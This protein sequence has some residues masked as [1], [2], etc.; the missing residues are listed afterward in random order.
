MLFCFKPDGMEEKGRYDKEQID[1]GGRYV[2]DSVNVNL[3]F[4]RYDDFFE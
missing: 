3:C 4:L 2:G 1:E